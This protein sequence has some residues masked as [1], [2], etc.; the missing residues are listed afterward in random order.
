MIYSFSRLS[1]YV[2]CPLRF[3]W[4]YIEKRSEPITEPLALGKAVHHSLEMIIKNGLSIEEAIYEGWIHTNFFPL[5]RFEMQWLIRNARAAQGMGR[6]EE[7][8]L[9]PLSTSPFSPNIQGYIDLH[10]YSWL[11]DW[12]TNRKTYGIN[13]SMQVLLYAW[14]LMQKF[15]VSEVKGTLYFLRY[16]LPVSAIFD[17]HQAEKARLWAYDTAMEIDE[18]RFLINDYPNKVNQL[19]PPKPSSICKHCPWALE[20][21]QKKN[22]QRERSIWHLI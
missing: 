16:K 13:D 5:K 7:H 10:N 15:G 14:A 21:Y 17:N 4:K 2:Q 22:T 6:V 1:L 3:Y 12:K 19:F 11:L 18:K 9:L 8:F 20:C